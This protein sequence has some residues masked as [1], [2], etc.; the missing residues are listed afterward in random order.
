[1]QEPDHAGYRPRRAWAI[2]PQVREV[3]SEAAW[4]DAREKLPEA[5]CR[6]ETDVSMACE[7]VS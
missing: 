7:N 5:A 2:A 6:W 4:R 1:M 3:T